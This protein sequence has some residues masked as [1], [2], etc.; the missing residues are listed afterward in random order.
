MISVLEGLR[1]HPSLSFFIPLPRRHEHG[2]LDILVVRRGLRFPQLEG[3]HPT[4]R[5]NL[6]ISSVSLIFSQDSVL[7]ILW[8]PVSF[9]P[10]SNTPVM[11]RHRLPLTIIPSSLH[12]SSILL[13][14]PPPCQGILDFLVVRTS[15]ARPSILRRRVGKG[16][17]MPYP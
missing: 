16:N 7:T 3:C 12:P 17:F 11:T 13:P 15:E 4:T 14:C 6:H 5:Y 10:P 2:L 1:P 9:P 8:F